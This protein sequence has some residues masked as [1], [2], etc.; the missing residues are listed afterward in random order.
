[1]QYHPVTLHYNPLKLH[2]NPIKIQYN[3]LK[4]PYNSSWT[5]GLM[6]RS[7]ELLNIVFDHCHGTLDQ[8]H[9]GNLSIR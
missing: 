7:W 3:S 5:A 4:L 8:T 2:Y 1:M 9:L 6:D